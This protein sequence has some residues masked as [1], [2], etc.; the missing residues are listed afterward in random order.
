MALSKLAGLQSAVLI[1]S[2]FPSA[3][4]NIRPSLWNEDLTDSVSVS[5]E[6]TA[7]PMETCQF[8]LKPF[9]ER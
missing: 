4:L 6:G 9:L 8:T 2:G 1:L 7:V 5:S 3:H